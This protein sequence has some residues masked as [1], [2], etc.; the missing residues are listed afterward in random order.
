MKKYEKQTRRRSYFKSDKGTVCLLEIKG[1][2]L[3]SHVFKLMV[4]LRR[5]KLAVSH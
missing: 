4:V 3:M 2:N 1:L 5:A